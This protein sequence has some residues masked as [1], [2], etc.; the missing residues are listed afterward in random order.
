MMKE[1]VLKLQI[2]PVNFYGAAEYLA[3]AE[4]LLYKDFL[5]FSDILLSVKKK[6]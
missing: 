5:L 6:S 3:T 4:S 2:M 1:E